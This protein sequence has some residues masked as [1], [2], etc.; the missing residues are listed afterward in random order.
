MFKVVSRLAVAGSV[1]ALVACGGQ[2]SEDHLNAAR[3]FIQAK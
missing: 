3:Q 2:T 1:F